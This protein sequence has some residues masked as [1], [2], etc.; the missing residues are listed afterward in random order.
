MRKLNHIKVMNIF[1]KQFIPTKYMGLP[2]Y[3]Y[4]YTLAMAILY[5]LLVYIHIDVS[6]LYIG[7]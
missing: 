2:L 6:M 7:I 3:Y 1:C 5:L 4:H